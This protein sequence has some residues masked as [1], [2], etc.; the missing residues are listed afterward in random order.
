MI[1]GGEHELHCCNRVVV[2]V[3]AAD[4]AVVVVVVVIAAFKLERS[5]VK[6]DGQPWRS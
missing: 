2:V 6:T 4:V 5:S 1:N 3:A